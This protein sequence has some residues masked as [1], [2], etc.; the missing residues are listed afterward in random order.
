MA[1]VYKCSALETFL[2]SLY[3]PISKYDPEKH[4]KEEWEEISLSK[5]N[6]NTKNST[7]YL[8]HI[9]K[10]SQDLYLSDFP[11][12][13]ALKAIAMGVA[14]PFYAMGVMAWNFLKIL[15]DV[16]SIFWKVLPQ[17]IDDFSRI[18]IVD[19]LG[20][21]FMAS[22]WEIPTE[23]YK[24][25]WRIARAPRY[26]LGLSLA[27]AYAVIS[28]LEGRKWISKI[29]L[30][31]HEGISYRGNLPCVGKKKTSLYELIQHLAAGKFIFL[32]YCM[33]KRGNLQDQ[34]NGISKFKIHR[35]TIKSKG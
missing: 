29:E 22:V 10:S 15:V 28:P 13:I 34:F 7:A 12:H 1:E 17:L 25:I 35:Q 19:A 27:C 24:D 16:S 33:Q 26:S 8:Y 2:A 18:G 9:E 6:Q 11:H 32:G 20:N 4:Q 21:A 14:T 23:V 3:S 5:R 31:W 30:D